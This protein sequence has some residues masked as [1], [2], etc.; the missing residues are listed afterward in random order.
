MTCDCSTPKGDLVLKTI[1]MPADTNSNGD[2]FGGW[3][4]SQ[5]DI[6]GGIL[7][8]EYTGG[9]IVTVA[10]SNI[11]F[12]GPIKAGDIFCCYGTVTKTGN[13]S[14][15]I[16]LE[17]WVTPVVRKTAGDCPS[18]MVTEAEFTYVAIDENGNKRKIKA[19]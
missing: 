7:A 4:M 12:L 1:A 17:V 6:A 16:K 3:I 13:T 19:S 8:K 5:M 18:T 14:L 15:T 2:M 11:I 9:R 10:V